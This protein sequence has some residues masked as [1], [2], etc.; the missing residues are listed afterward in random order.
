MIK[1]KLMPL[2]EGSA[3][4]LRASKSRYGLYSNSFH[5]S[6]DGFGRKNWAVI[7]NFDV[8]HEKYLQEGKTIE[9][10][11]EECIEYLNTPPKSKYGKIRKRKPLYGAFHEIPHKVK[12]IEKKNKKYIQALLIVN[13]KKSRHFWG[14]GPVAKTRKK[15]K[16]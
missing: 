3:N 14:E 10:I 16:R 6:V 4:S 11:V 8:D 12:L 2:Y 9:E 7:V 5:W 13:K 15:K 1:C